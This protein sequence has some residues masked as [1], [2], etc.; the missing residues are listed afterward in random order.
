RFGALAAEVDVVRVQGDAHLAGGVRQ[1][2]EIA[3]KEDSGRVIGLAFVVEHIKLD[4]D[5]V[6]NALIAERAAPTANCGG[7]IRLNEKSKT[8]GR[9]WLRPLV[10]ANLE[11]SGKAP[12]TDA[13]YFGGAA[14]LAEIVVQPQQVFGRELSAARRH[15]VAVVLEARVAGREEVRDGD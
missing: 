4:R 13:L 3:V 12:D 5:A 2:G 15:H 14:G 6:G 1:A 11:R 8:V 9:I 10:Q 7:A